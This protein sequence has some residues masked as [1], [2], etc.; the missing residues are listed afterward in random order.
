MVG[1]AAVLSTS[2]TAPNP[3][4]EWTAVSV[5]PMGWTAKNLD[6]ASMMSRVRAVGDV[7]TCRSILPRKRSPPGRKGLRLGER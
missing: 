7:K 3:S 2:K 5:F 6:I 4:S 1:G